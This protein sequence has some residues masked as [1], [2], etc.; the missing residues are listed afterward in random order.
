VWG[1]SG[2]SRWIWCEGFAEYLFGRGGTAV[3]SLAKV[4]Q[5]NG[6]RATVTER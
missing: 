5:T 2:V 4:T 1:E 3:G 6:K